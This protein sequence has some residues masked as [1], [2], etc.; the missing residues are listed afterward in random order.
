M[1]SFTLG[2][3]LSSVIQS[4]ADSGVVMKAFCRCDQSSLSVCFKEGRRSSVG[5]IQS[6]QG[7]SEQNW[8]SLRKKKLC[9]Y[10]R[11]P[12]CLS[13]ALSLFCQ[14]SRRSYRPVPYCKPLNINFFLV[15]FLWFKLDGF[16]TVYH[17]PAFALFLSSTYMH[18]YIHTAKTHK[19][20][21]S[22]LPTWAMP[23]VQNSIRMCKQWS[24]E[25]YIK[26]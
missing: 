10:L 9:L 4:D 19:I 1:V 8:V 2:S 20:K 23:L 21:S 5:L 7:P 12:A 24:V 3:P 25:H 18:P 13:W 15:L 26:N 6:V 17:L 16:T 11:V 14:D 22:S